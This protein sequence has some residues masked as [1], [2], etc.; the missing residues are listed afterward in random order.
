MP[1]KNQIIN[2]INSG[3][4]AKLVPSSIAGAGVGVITL[5]E[6]YKNEIVFAPKETHFIQWDAIKL[7]ENNVIRYIKQVC[8]HNE[9]GFWIDCD[10]N[11]I[12][13]AYFVNHSDDPNL[14][15][16]KQ[17]D[18]YFAIKD[19]KIGEELTCKYSSDEID[20]V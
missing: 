18:I 6:I 16:D 15:H 7:T 2:R 10:I 17:K 9:N 13:A 8:N 5:T 12:G 11:D 14:E 3:I 4:I 1:T 20:W 19:I